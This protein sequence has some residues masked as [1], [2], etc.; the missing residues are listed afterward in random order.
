MAGAREEDRPSCR[1][2]AGAAPAAPATHRSRARLRCCS[3]SAA[4]HWGDIVGC[5]QP[6]GGTLA[7]IR[8][9]LAARFGL[10]GDCSPMPPDQEPEPGPEPGPGP[11]Q[12]PGP[13]PE[14]EPGPEPGPGQEP[15]HATAEPPVR[16]QR[17]ALPVHRPTRQCAA[18]E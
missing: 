9:L 6:K 18:A 8:A 3:N 13:G 7:D 14:P 5:L 15:M 16:P 10:E 1:A 2:R 12:E 4:Q 17:F 11:G